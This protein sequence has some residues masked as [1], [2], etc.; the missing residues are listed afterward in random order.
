MITKETTNRVRL[1]YGIHI[2]A[3]K[4]WQKYLDNKTW[5]D[6]MNLPS[7]LVKN[8]KVEYK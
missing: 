6:I 3:N 8:R 4:T 1:L 5:H 7:I 2:F